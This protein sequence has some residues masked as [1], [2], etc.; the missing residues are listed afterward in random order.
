[1]KCKKSRK[2]SKNIEKFINKYGLYILMGLFVLGPIIINWM[3]RKNSEILGFTKPDM[4]DYYGVIVS[5][6]I[7]FL[8]LR[9]TVNNNN[10]TTREQF[11]FQ[12]RQRQIET[13][14]NEFKKN[15]VYIINIQT[16][17]YDIIDYKMY[18]DLRRK[19]FIVVM[20]NFVCFIIKLYLMQEEKFL[21]LIIS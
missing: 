12:I 6:V 11:N 3:F 21:I 18:G 13:F 4:L 8:V 7:T 16:Q 19:K 5:G 10:E 20:K 17:I 15:I 2:I 9:I 14:E 1:M